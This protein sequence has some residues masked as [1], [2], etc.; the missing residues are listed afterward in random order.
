MPYPRPK[1]P[2]GGIKANFPGFI[3]P[4]S[5]EHL[6]REPDPVSDLD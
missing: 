1:P 4:A 6:L 5:A 3:E 2:S